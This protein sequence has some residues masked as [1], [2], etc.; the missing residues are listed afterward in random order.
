MNAPVKIKKGD[1]VFLAKGKDRGKKGKVIRVFPD[2]RKILVEGVNQK[3]RHTRPRRSGEKGQ[4]VTI[5][6]PVKAANVVL[7][8]P[9]CG[10]GT[11]VGYRIEIGVKTRR[12]KK[13]GSDI[14]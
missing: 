7:I 9:N 8:C 11:R 12:C 14:T 3:I 6:H 2:T 13:C 4:R 5:T 10:K 1:M